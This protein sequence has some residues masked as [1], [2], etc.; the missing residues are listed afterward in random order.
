MKNISSRGRPDLRKASA[1]GSSLRYTTAES[2]WGGRAAC[3]SEETKIGRA[4]KEQKKKK[5]RKKRGKREKKDWG[6]GW[7]KMTDM[8]IARFESV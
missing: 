3:V 7:G 6:N 1:H 8:P 2:I 4:F 5:G